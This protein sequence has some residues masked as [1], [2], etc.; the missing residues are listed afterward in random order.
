MPEIRAVIFDMDGVLVDSEPLYMEQERLSYA[1]YGVALDTAGLSRFVGTTQQYMW[2]TIKA[3]H[4]LAEPL[5]F[6]MA[7]HQ[8]QVVRAMGMAPLSAMPGVPDFLVKL[9]EAEIPCAVAS[10][11]PAELVGVILRKTALLPFFDRV[12]CGTDVK[13]SKPDPEI[14]L[15][16]A[17]R[18]GVAPHECAVIEDSSHGVAAAKAAGMFCIGFVNPHSGLQDLSAAD[19]HVRHHDEITKWFLEQ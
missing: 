5:D 17:G 13:N 7:Q 18:L 4:G 16:A 15:L 8:K 1:R 6:L 2:S 14:F 3:E 11:S 10:S 19:R 9:K 12:V